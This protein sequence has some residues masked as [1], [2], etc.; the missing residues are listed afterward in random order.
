[1][2]KLKISN[3]PLTHAVLMHSLRLGATRITS[4]IALSLDSFGI[5]NFLASITADFVTQL[6]NEYSF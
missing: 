2:H 5:A 1:M 4:V 3:M 6:T